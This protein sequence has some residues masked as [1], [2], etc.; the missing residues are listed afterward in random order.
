[1][2]EKLQPFQ[3]L[4]MVEVSGKFQAVVVLLSGEITP[5]HRSFA[6]TNE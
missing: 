6:E 1:M 5:L 2:E 3:P 4:A